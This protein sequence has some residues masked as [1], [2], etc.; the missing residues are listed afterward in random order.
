MRLGVSLEAM[1]RHFLT[2]G[3]EFP[4]SQFTPKEHRPFSASRL[5]TLPTNV[6]GRIPLQR[7]ERLA[8]SVA[9]CSLGTETSLSSIDGGENAE[10][11]GWGEE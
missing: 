8:S 5:Q 4:Q 2:I 11:R 3:L 6:V 10:L 1:W 7:L 9:S